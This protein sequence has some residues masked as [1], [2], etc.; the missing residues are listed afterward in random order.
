MVSETLLMQKSNILLL[1]IYI[2]I[3]S[4]WKY[5]FQR[6]CVQKYKRRGRWTM[7]RESLEYV[8]WCYAIAASMQEYI[9]ITND[10]VLGVQLQP[11]MYLLAAPTILS[12]SSFHK[13][14]LLNT[15]I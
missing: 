1:T 5:D 3:Y 15:F 11:T 13:K 8:N 6:K 12:G 14:K 9:S 7:R 4:W 10:R 2:H